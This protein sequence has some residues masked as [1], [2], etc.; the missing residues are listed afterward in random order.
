[1][2][3]HPEAQSTPQISHLFRIVEIKPFCHL[4]HHSLA[5]MPLGAARRLFQSDTIPNVAKR[6]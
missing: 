3:E 5:L 4:V 6:L 2:V 1:M